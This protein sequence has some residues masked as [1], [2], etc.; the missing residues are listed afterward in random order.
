MGDPARIPLWTAI[1]A[2]AGLGQAV[3]LFANAIFVWCY[4]RETKKL[5]QAAEEQVNIGQRQVE[6]SFRPA[7]VIQHWRSASELAAVN[8]GSGPAI[9]VHWSLLNTDLKGTF[10]YLRQDSDPRNLGGTGWDKKLTNAALKI[11]PDIAQIEC[12]YRSLSGWRYSSINTYDVGSASFTTMFVDHGPPR[13]AA[14]DKQ[15]ERG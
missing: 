12:L 14:E 2:L 5:R 6:V 7:V 4:L 13:K 10:P 8:I 3:L 1:V 11:R 15:K 9:D